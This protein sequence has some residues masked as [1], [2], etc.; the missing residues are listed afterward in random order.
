MKILFSIIGLSCLGLLAGCGGDDDGGASTTVDTG[1]AE[2]KALSAVSSEEARSACEHMRDAMQ[3]VIDPDSILNMVCTVMS[4]AA[5]ESEAECNQEKADCVAEYRDQLGDS[6]E[7]DFECD[8]DTS[9]FQGCDVKVGVLES[10][11]NDTLDEFRAV[12]SR[13]SCKDAGK[14]DSDQLD[15]LGSFDVEPPTSCQ[16]LIDQCDGAGVITG[17]GDDDADE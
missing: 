3:E 4:A 13:Y 9:E 15:G 11:L 16:P 2:D 12:L 1:I 8:G 7:V 6:G 10:C 5:T 14:I 17:A